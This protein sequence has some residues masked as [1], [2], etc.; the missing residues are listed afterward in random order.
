MKKL[1]CVIVLLTFVGLTLVGCFGQSQLPVDPTD[2][3]SNQQDKSS[4]EKYIV[5]NFT[6]TYHVTGLIDPGSN[7]VV[8]EKLITKGQVIE[9][10]YDYLDNALVGGSL[11]L[12][13]NSILDVNT[14]EGPVHGNFVITP[15][16]ANAGGGVWEGI[17]L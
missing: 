10:T 3:I 11:T 6:A 9:C 5:T 16:S 15:N 12:Y 4:L 1:K 14:G 17:W 8:R 2:Q 7:K 13:T